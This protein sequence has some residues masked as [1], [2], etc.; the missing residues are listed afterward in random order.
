MAQPQME[1]IMN[2]SNSPP[3]AYG[4]MTGTICRVNSL[5][6]E[7]AVRTSGE[8]VEFDVPVECPVLL[9]GERVKLRLLQPMDR[10][11]V[12]YD[13]SQGRRQARS[14]RVS[15]LKQEEASELP[16]ARLA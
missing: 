10:A 15:W 8:L 3:R 16:A 6:R 11:Q 13:E 9:N 12:T 1:T 14:I 5:T 4:E 7:I 2:P